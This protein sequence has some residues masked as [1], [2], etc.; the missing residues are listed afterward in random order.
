MVKASI[1]TFDSKT[2]L[3]IKHSNEG[4]KNCFQSVSD[5][6]IGGPNNMNQNNVSRINYDRSCAFESIEK[7]LKQNKDSFDKVVKNI[8]I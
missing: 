1:L 3:I 7:S 6:Y 8:L 5:E 2:S 4:P